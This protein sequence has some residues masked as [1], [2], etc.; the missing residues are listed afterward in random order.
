MGEGLSGFVCMGTGHPI[1]LVLGGPSSL[2]GLGRGRHLCVEPHLGR[3]CA[4]G[5]VRL[6]PPYCG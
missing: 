2:G 3:R 6:P 5:A 4:P 1:E